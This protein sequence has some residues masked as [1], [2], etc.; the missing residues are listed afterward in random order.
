MATERQVI[1]AHLIVF[2][3]IYK[4]RYNIPTRC[5]IK[6]SYKDHFPDSDCDNVKSIKA[7]PHFKRLLNWTLDD[8]L[9]NI[10]SN[11]HLHA[12]LAKIMIEEE[13]LT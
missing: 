3:C 2:P 7:E 1:K 9:L 10:N 12:V 6:E 8:A 11:V 4:C 5:T 13:A